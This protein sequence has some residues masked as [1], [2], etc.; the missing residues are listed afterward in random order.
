M[1]SLSHLSDDELRSKLKEF[2]IK[3][4]V[5]D[6]TRSILLKKLNHLYSTGKNQPP[7]SKNVSNVS[8]FNQIKQGRKE[9]FS[10]NESPIRI[11]PRSRNVNSRFSTKI[12]SNESDSHINYGS[13]NN[14]SS[15]EEAEGKIFA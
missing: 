7:A 8:K 1:A 4:P 14:F 2:G 10:K 11:S 3:T 12:K 15:D 5:T 9:T 13:L 6:S